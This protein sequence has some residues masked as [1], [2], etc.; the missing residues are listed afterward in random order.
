[1]AVQVQCPHC[2]K[3]CQI[4]PDHIG[5]AVRCPLCGQV[6][7]PTTGP[8][9]KAASGAR[10]GF[11]QGLRGVVRSLGAPVPAARLTET[12]QRFTLNGKA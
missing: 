4:Q 1:M 2:K 6:F 5:R 3:L 11:W 8:A 10:S 12:M 7:A 9:E